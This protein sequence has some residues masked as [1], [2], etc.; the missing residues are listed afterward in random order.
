MINQATDLQDAKDLTAASRKPG[1]CVA[2][3]KSS[4]VCQRP[5]FTNWNSA[6]GVTA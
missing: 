3:R 6:F 2:A 5:M 1:L 4:A